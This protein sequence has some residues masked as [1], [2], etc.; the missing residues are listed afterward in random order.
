MTRWINTFAALNTICCRC[1]YCIPVD[2]VNI[3]YW[4]FNIIII[5]KKNYCCYCYSINDSLYL[6]MLASDV[7]PYVCMYDV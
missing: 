2:V 4:S 7:C 5:K 6:I 3:N 1:C